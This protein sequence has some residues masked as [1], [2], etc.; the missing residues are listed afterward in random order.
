MALR[1]LD[2]R[3]GAEGEAL[4]PAPG[5]ASLQGAVVGMIDN[6]KVGTARLLDHIGTILRRDHGVRELLRVRKSDPS[7][8]APRELLARI[9]GAD[10]ILAAT[11]D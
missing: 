6:S 1:V 3:L 5:L 4:R 2:P 9:S 10:A 8:P 11:G 7:R